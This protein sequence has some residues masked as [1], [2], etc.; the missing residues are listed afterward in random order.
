M[1]IKKC[2][3]VK[4]NLICFQ[5]LLDILINKCVYASLFYEAELAELVEL[6]L[7]LP[8]FVWRES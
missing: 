1:L 7:K 6:L 2:S 5:Y 8:L 4:Q 3:P